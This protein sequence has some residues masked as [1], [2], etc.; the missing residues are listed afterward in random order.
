MP[1]PVVHF[2]VEGKDGAKLQKF[3]SDLFDWK[4][5]ANNPMNYGLVVNEGEGIG[6]GISGGE[7]PHV[8]FYVSVDDPAAYLKKAQALGG[9]VV[10]DVTEIPG[11][12]T[13][14]QFRDPEGNMIGIIANEMASEYEQRVEAEK[15][16]AGQG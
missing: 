13:M 8:T 7:S 6:G 5:D 12:V 14:A 4:I 10:M 9:T 11:M 16:G 3:Y 1:N 15:A 2:E